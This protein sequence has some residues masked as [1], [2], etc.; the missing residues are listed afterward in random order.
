MLQ[1]FLADSATRLCNSLLE[2]KLS[3]H[4]FDSSKLML[5]C[6][7]F[8]F[9]FQGFVKIMNQSDTCRTPFFAGNAISKISIQSFVNR[10][11]GDETYKLNSLMVVHFFVNIC[12]SLIGIYCKC[13]WNTILYFWY[14][15]VFKNVLWSF[16]HQNQTCL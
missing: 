6:G 11:S 15:L 10:H 5:K 9:L 1:S 7:Y 3:C 14:I 16:V 8:C 12:F 13:P 4:P 2:I